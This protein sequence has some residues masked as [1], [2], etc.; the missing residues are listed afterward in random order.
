[1]NKIKLLDHASHSS[2]VVSCAAHQSAVLNSNH[3]NP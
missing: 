1:L 2:T 3:S